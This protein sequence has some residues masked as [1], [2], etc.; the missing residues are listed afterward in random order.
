[1]ATARGL[2]SP[3]RLTSRFHVWPDFHGNRAPLAEPSLLG[4]VN[5][6]FIWVFLGLIFQDNSIFFLFF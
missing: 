4:M 6:S 2:S 1:M 5:I 3:A